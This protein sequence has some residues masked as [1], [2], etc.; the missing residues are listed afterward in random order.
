M[1]SRSL[2]SRLR[3]SS[4][5]RPGLF[6]GRLGL[7]ES[8]YQRTSRIAS[9]DAVAVEERRS[10]VAPFVSGRDW[11]RLWHLVPSRAG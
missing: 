2:S 5:L 1:T 6:A 3:R 9:L 7:P 4:Q 10:W 8:F 11:G